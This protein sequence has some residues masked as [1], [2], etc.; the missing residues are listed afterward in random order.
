M[1]PKPLIPTRTVIWTFFLSGPLCQQTCEGLRQSG[2]TVYQSIPSGQGISSAEIPKFPSP[3]PGSC[4]TAQ[5][6]Q[7]HYA[8]SGR[9]SVPPRRSP[10]VSGTSGRR[11]H[12][13]TT[14]ARRAGHGLGDAPHRGGGQHAGEERSG[15]DDDLVRRQYPLH[16]QGAAGR[17]RAPGTPCWMLPAATRPPGRPPAVSDSALSTTRSR[18]P[19]GRPRSPPAGRPRRTPARGRRWRRPARPGSGCPAR[20]RPARPRRSGAR[21]RR[22]APSPRRPGRPGTCAGRPE[23]PR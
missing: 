11:L 6:P 9:P 18:W 21:R 1:R 2:R 10:A 15:A 16:G 22:P 7:I 17:P 3:Y 20:A 12:T 23:P 13:Y 19:A 8:C 5:R 4:H 14:L